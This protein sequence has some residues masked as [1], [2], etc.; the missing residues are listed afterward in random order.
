MPPSEEM[1]VGAWIVDMKM[2]VKPVDGV[3]QVW[4]WGTLDIFAR[5]RAFCC[6][7]VHFN[8]F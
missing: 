7:N 4:N 2:V 3:G 8:N 5:R 6:R 1:V